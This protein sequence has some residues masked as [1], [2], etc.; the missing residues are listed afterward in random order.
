MQEPQSLQQWLEW[1]RQAFREH[2]L[3][4]GHGTDNPEDE[5]MYLIRYVLKQ[6]FEIACLHPERILAPEKNRQIQALFQK[7]IASRK[8]AAYL[9][10]E[11]WFAGYPF[12]VDERVLVPRSPLAELILEQFS[13]WVEVDKVRTILDIGTGS[14]C[15]AI[16]CALTLPDTQVDAVDVQETALEV[17]RINIANHHLESRVRLFHADIYNGLPP[18]RYDIII[19]NPPYVSLGEMQDLPEEYRHEPVSGLAA[20]L[21]GLDCVRR[22]LSGANDYLSPSGILVVEVGNSQAAVEQA[23]PQVPFIWL[24]FEYGGEGVFLLEAK[25]VYE[26][27][28]QFK[29][30][31]TA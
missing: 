15:I 21:D 24:E 12:Y 14:G 18:A 4:F 29:F 8:P 7:R 16:A 10:N 26:F 28:D 22:I 5:A 2:D 6:D 20:G 1:S 13:P 31:E 25:H 17:A 11:A 19:S 9:V 27:H 30:K 3:F 23:W